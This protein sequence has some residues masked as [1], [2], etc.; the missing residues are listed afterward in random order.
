MRWSFVRGGGFRASRC[1]LFAD[2]DAI[3]CD[4]LCLSCKGSKLM[5]LQSVAQ[6]AISQSSQIKLGLTMPQKQTSFCAG[7]YNS[8]LSQL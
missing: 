2:F 1:V 7:G 3:G 6:P 4:W 8:N 5:P